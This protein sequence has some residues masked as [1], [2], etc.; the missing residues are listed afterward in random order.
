MKNVWQVQHDRQS[1]NEQSCAERDLF[2]IDLSVQEVP[3]NAVLEDQGRVTKSQDA[4]LKKAGKFNTFSDEAK[5]TVQQLG[6]IELFAL[7]EV[8][9]KIQCLSCAKYCP[10]GLLCCICGK[11]SRSSKEQ[12][13]KTKEEFDALSIPH[14]IVKNIR[15]V[16]SMGDPKNSTITPKA[17]ESTRHA[18]KKGYDSITPRFQG[19]DFFLNSQIDIGWIEEHCQYLD[20]HTANDFPYT[21]TRLER[22]RSEHIRL[23]A[24]MVKVRSLDQ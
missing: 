14:H 17:N 15:D 6:K 10:E 23:L 18:G 9:T 2:K 19:D 1:S 16:Q 11:C 20:S 5:K 8:S 12:T 3:Q 24:S 22:T 21:A 13:R 7:G 4:D